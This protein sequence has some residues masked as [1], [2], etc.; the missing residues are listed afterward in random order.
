MLICEELFLLL[1]RDDGKP[2]S[3]FSQNGYGL[4]AAAVTDLILAERVALSDDKDPR[5]R[6]VNPQPTGHPA[7]DAAL[8]R[9]A[10]KDDRKL[11]ACVVDAKVN[12]EKQVV[13]AL[14]AAGVIDVEEKR[15]LGFVPEK[16]PIR[17]AAHEQAVRQRLAAV[18]AGARP[19][20]ADATLLAILQGIDLAPRVLEQEKGELG[21]KELKARIEQ[22]THDV[23]AGTA[24]TKAVQS[25]NAAIM[26]AVIIP[27][28]VTGSS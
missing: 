9:L 15:A 16:Y 18:L 25:M 13:Q 11:S 21:K 24:V 14:A 5:V 6:V 12:P 19:T 20:V 23:P 2:E 22:V 28:V 10:D 17:D 27:T 1:R 3:A 4:A 26:T 7:L 8:A